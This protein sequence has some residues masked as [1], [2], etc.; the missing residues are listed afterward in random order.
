[1]RRRVVL[2]A[3]ALVACAPSQARLLDRRHFP[4]AL[5]GVDEGALDGGAVLAAIAAG[6][7]SGCMFKLS[8]GTC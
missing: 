3:L 7:R 1:M 6:S 2:L 4:E 8:H 5:A